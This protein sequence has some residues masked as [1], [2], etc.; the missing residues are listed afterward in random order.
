M[1]FKFRMNWGEKYNLFPRMDVFCPLIAGF[2]YSFIISAMQE[3]KFS[4]NLV[5]LLAEGSK[6][7]IISLM[8]YSRQLSQQAPNERDTFS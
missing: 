1:H 2:I 7:Q 4:E 3:E 5:T 8:T 6:S